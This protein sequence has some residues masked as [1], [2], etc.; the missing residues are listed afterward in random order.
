M[1]SSTR[2]LGRRAAAAVALAAG[3]SITLASPALA[4][5]PG[6][7]EAFAAQAQVSLPLIGDVN[8][9]PVSPSNSVDP[10]HAEVA[11]ITGNPI[12]TA[13]LLTSDSAFD[14]EAGATSAAASVADAQVLPDLAGVGTVLSVGLLQAECSGTQDGLS[15]SANLADVSALNGAVEIPLNPGPNTQI[16]IDV[17]GVLS[18]SLVLNE[19]IS[20]ADGSLTV[21][22]L[23]ITITALTGAVAGD[24]V[25]GSVTCGAGVAPGVPLLSVQGFAIGLVGAA[26][27][28]VPAMLVAR[29][30]RTR[31]EAIDPLGD[32]R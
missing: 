31:R 13:G 11:S 1:T 14:A 5:D 18:L 7:S 6:H 21:N 24:I 19:Q 29:R 32:F 3:V 22:A 2:R 30:M 23:H 15:G 8:V 25:L 28:G 20:N 9:G 26:V 16:P 17:T 27:I 4:V 10:T 12:L